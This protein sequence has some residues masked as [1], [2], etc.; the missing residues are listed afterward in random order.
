[1]SD[2]KSETASKASI[3]ANRPFAGG[4][5]PV[6]RP[7][8]HTEVTDRLRRMIVR[9]ELQPGERINELDLATLLHVSRTPLREA[10]KLLQSEGLITQQPNRSAIVSP[11]T[12]AETAELFEALAGI[13]RLGGELT[14]RRIDADGLAYLRH[15]HD[16]MFSLHAAGDQ[17]AY[18]ELNDRIHRAF[19]ELSANTRLINIHAQLIA[20]ATRIRYAALQEDGR[21]EESVAEHKDILLAVAEGDDR[22]VGELIAQH[23][24]Q[25]GARVCEV[26]EPLSSGS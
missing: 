26:L 21:W 10:L 3:P 14:T 7:P 2:W 25:T 8:L 12:Q 18:F 22:Q 5:Q 13:E 11:I 15:L 23:V 16:E 9:L 24:L 6:F 4:V 20:G 17:E 1:M 19:V